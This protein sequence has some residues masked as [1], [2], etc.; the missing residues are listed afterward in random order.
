M[1][2]LC[3]DILLASVGFGGYWLYS[4]VIKPRRAAASEEAKLVNSA[5]SE[6]IR[7]ENPAEIEYEKTRDMQK[8]NFGLLTYKYSSA[9]GSI[10]DLRG[11]KYYVLFYDDKI[12]LITK[13][14][15]IIEFNLPINLITKYY[16]T[17][18][19][20]ELRLYFRDPNYESADDNYI[21]FD[22]RDFDKKDDKVNEYALKKIDLPGY[23]SEN[24]KKV[25]KTT[26]SLAA[27]EETKFEN[28]AGSE[29]AKL[30]NSAESEKVKP[31]STAEIE[32][33]KIMDTYKPNLVLLAYKSSVRLSDLR[34]LD[35]SV[36]YILFYDDKISLITKDELTTEF[37]LP[38]NLITRY[39]LADNDTKLRLY[40]KEPN[41]EYAND[42]YFDFDFKFYND[43]YNKI[44]EYALRQIDLPEYLSENF[45]KALETTIDTVAS[46]RAKPENSAEIEYKKIID[47]LM[48]NLAL[49]VRMSSVSLSGSRYLSSGDYYVLFYNDKIRIIT[50]KEPIAEFNL[51]INLITMYYFINNDTKLRLYFREPNDKSA[52]DNFIDLDLNYIPNSKYIINEYALKQF[53]LPK[54]LSENFK[55]APKTTIDL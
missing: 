15:P 31:E 32:H 36:C 37:S 10:R 14:E 43:T 34:L 26:I 29:E 13:D 53:D 25:P 45:K 22:I 5:E 49:L 19:D 48:P 16:L 54:Y 44:N 18:N 23:L 8:P 46:E 47:T 52:K 4:S 33:N 40:F 30:V 42:K 6:K 55:N 20:T 51:P 41:V 38:I 17:N 3:L 21:H 7:L 50:E 9:R 12:R 35:S 39:Y 2:Y 27:S 1:L 11:D 28:P 24:F